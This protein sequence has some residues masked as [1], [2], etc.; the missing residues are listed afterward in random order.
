VLPTL[1]EA[2]GVT[3]PPGLQ[4]Q[5][6]MPL[7]QGQEPLPEERLRLTRY[8][9]REAVRFDRRWK[10]VLEW[11]EGQVTGMRLYD[12]QEDPGEER[13]LA[14]TPEGR[15][16]ARDILRHYR[17]WRESTAGEDEAYRILQGEAQVEAEALAEI[18]ALGYA[19]GD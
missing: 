6:L 9:G 19:D 14:G 3:E 7:L 11:Q 13:D 4:G 17:A 2:L 18:E 12:L 16:W 5:S 15:P 1:L 8:A 10:L